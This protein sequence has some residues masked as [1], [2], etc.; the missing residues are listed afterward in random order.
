MTKSKRY[1]LSVKASNEDKIYYYVT[2]DVNGDCIT[3]DIRDAYRWSDSTKYSGGHD[4]ED[5]MFFFDE[6]SCDEK[7]VKVEQSTWTWEELK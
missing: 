3:D 6:E 7:M 2:D 4:F 5:E 1:V